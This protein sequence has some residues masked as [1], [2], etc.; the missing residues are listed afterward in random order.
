MV[1]VS[2]VKCVLLFF[3]K[4]RTAYEVL[5]SDWSSDV[6]ASDLIELRGFNVG[7]RCAQARGGLAAVAGARVVFLARD[8]VRGEQVFGAGRFARGEFVLR[9]GARELGLRLIEARLIRARLD[10]DQQAALLHQ[11]SFVEC[12]P[13]SIG[14]PSCRETDVPPLY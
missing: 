7:A 5:I 8:R 10:L 14:I 9:D 12:N 13:V 6:C 1:F 3:F 2:N 4:Q 11:P